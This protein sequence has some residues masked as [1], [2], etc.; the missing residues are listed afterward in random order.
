MLLSHWTKTSTPT[1]REEIDPGGALHIT[2]SH[3]GDRQKA[4]KA[5]SALRALKIKPKPG[6]G[7]AAAIRELRDGH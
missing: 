3:V 4:L 6:N 5:L 2:F 1:R 7:G